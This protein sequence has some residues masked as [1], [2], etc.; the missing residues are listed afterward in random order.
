M[1]TVIQKK[2]RN[3]NIELY[4]IILMFLMVANHY[5]SGSGLNQLIF[6]SI[7][8]KAIFFISLTSFGK[9]I[10]NGFL[11]ITG[12]F[13][14]TQEFKRIKILKLLFQIE[15]YKVFFYLFFLII[16]YESLS[17]SSILRAILPVTQVTNNFVGCF[18]VFY[19]LIPFLNILIQ[20][21]DEEKHRYLLFLLLFVY[22]MLG[23]I[24][25]IY[26][27][28]NYVTWFSC[29]YLIGA[30]LRKYPIK[31]LENRYFSGFATLILYLVSV[32][33]VVI[34]TYIQNRINRTDVQYW[35][36]SD[37][38]KILAVL[39]GVMSFMFFKNIKIKNSK[40][41]NIVAR[42]TFGVLLF[43]GVSDAMRNWLWGGIF[44]NLEFY[45]TGYAYIHLLFA[46]LVVFVVGTIFDM[47]RIRFIESWFIPFVDRTC[48]SIRSKMTK[49]SIPQ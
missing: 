26:V 15:F 20:H 40:F 48:D 6:D 44:K 19:F 14:C 49:K 16:G 29:V 3:S 46:T 7:D 1:D 42:S 36:L 35:F 12:W 33:S 47:A 18:L 17:V 43:H 34:C 25:M 38:N 31:K 10:I 24:P 41:I 23:T 28:F 21:M 22:V 13:M 11:M 4:R 32:L 37:S 45:N 2:E 39:L 8:V 30:Y 5:R 27:S 9:A